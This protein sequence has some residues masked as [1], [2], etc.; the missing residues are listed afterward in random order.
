MNSLRIWSRSVVTEDLLQFRQGTLAPLV[1]VVEG[2]VEA[3]D[4]LFAG[5]P[6]DE[7][8]LEHDAVVVVVDS[9]DRPMDEALRGGAALVG[10]LVEGLDLGALAQV[11]L[12]DRIEA[13]GLGAVGVALV[14]AAADVLVL[15]H[16][17]AAV[18]HAGVPARA[19]ERGPELR[20]GVAAEVGAH[21][22]DALEGVLRGLVVVGAGETRSAGKLKG[23]DA[24]AHAVVGAHAQLGPDLE[25]RGHAPA[26]AL[27][28]E[29]ADE[30]VVE[31]VG[32]SRA[33]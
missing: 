6:L 12:D 26:V 14:E 11:G 22:E 13:A 19:L 18:V 33:E 20:T 28:G 8:Q 7:G 10:L 5:Q 16:E 4:D 29:A 21:R 1:D 25:R 15:G 3:L 9:P 17:L 23:L 2:D 32:H 27:A 24:T 30:E 31:G